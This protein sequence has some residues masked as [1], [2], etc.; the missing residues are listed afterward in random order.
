MVVCSND[1]EV[2]FSQGIMLISGGS[3]PPW[4]F[5]PRLRGGAPS[6]RSKTKFQTTLQKY[7]QKLPPPP[8]E[9]KKIQGGKW[10]RNHEDQN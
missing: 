7:F 9:K 4:K 2:N 10:G 8:G 5:I 6:Q 3:T 1:S